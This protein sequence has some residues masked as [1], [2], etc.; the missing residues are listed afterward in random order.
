MEDEE[1]AEIWAVA[2]D[3]FTARVAVRAGVDDVEAREATEAV[4]GTLAERIPAGEVEDLLPR[5][6]V[7]LHRAVRGTVPG[8]SP[9]MGRDEFVDRVARRTG[10]PT[11]EAR[12][13]A[14]AVLATLRESVTAEEFFDLTVELPDEYRTLLAEA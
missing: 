3:A 10:A 14:R 12:E 5:L 11:D 4:L 1:T 8:S 2:S 7:A 13:Y 6:P 9:R